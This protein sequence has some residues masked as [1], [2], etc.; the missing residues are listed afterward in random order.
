MNTKKNPR[1]F[2][3][4]IYTDDKG[5]Y[6]F[7]NIFNKTA[8]LLSAAEDIKKYGIF[9]TRLALAIL[10]GFV[11]LNYLEM[12]ILGVTLGVVIYVVM[13]VIFY[14]K[15]INGLAVVKDFDIEAQDSFLMRY[16]GPLSNT[17]IVVSIV[18]LVAISLL[19]IVNVNVSDFDELIVILNYVISGIAALVAVILTVAYIIKLRTAKGGKKK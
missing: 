12:P 3:L 18:L 1:L 11:V 8:Y 6:V 19:I 2:G 5:R 13:T 16:L 14:T 10:V 7:Y 4:H 9:Q 17:R 15:F